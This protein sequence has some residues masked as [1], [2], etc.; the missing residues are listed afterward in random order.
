MQLTAVA[1]R[2]RTEEKR[3]ANVKTHGVDFIA[4]AAFEWQSAVVEV[5]DRDDYCELRERAL[6]FVGMRL[7]MLVFTRRGDNIRI[8]SLRKAEKKVVLIRT[9]QKD[10]K[11]KRRRGK[12]LS[13][14]GHCARL[15][16]SLTREDTEVTRGALADPDNHSSQFRA[17]R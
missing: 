1:L 2:R 9:C 11:G 12:R 13:G 10:P 14:R 7:H 16:K 3:N 5:D 4:A 17:H 15:R 8:I 6:G